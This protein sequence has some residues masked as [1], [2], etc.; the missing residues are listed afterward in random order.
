M[1]QLGLKFN[2]LKKLSAFRI[3]NELMQKKLIKAL[4]HCNYDKII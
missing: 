2:S 1:S 3:K 4:K